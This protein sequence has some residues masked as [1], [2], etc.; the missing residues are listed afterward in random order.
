MA[1]NS[2]FGANFNGFINHYRIENALMLMPRQDFK[3]STIAA[4][5]FEA[6]FNSLTSFNTAFKKE[7]GKTPSAYRKEMS[8]RT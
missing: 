3:N 6:G 8:L 5:A 4:I 2:R 1:I 7:T